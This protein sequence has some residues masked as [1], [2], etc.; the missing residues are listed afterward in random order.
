MSEATTEGDVPRVSTGSDV[1]DTMLGGGLPAQRSVLLTGGPGTG[2]STLAMQFLQQGL[3]EGDECLFLSTE[4]TTE[5]LRMGFQTFDFDLDHEN[6][7]LSTIHAAPRESRTGE[8]EMVIRTLEGE[9]GIDDKQVPFTGENLVKYLDRMGEFDRIV[10]DSV[11]GLEPAA[12]DTETFRRIVLDLIRAINDRLDGT[13]ILTAE[14]SGARA[15]E[16]GAEHVAGTDVIQYSAHGVIRVWREALDGDYQRF[17]DIMK[18][19]GVDHDTRK[20]K[21]GFTDEGMTVYP[22]HRS[23]SD[24]FVQYERFPTGL[25][26][27][28]DLLGG[29]LLQG[30][31]TL[32]EHDG[33]ASL[34]ALFSAMLGSAL[35]DEMAL[36]LVPR[37]DMKPRRLE[38]LLYA[39]DR[40][41]GDLLDDD[42]LFVLD[43]VGAWGMEHRNVFD[44]MNADSGL[45]YLFQQIDDRAA[46]DGRFTMINTE[47]KIHAIGDS[48]ARRIRDWQQ[49]HYVGDD[50]I[51]LEVHNPVQMDDQLSEFHSDA[52]GQVMETYMDESGLQY[53]S[54]TKSPTGLLGSTRVLEFID[55]E[56]Y[57][58]VR[59][60]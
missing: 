5:E 48:E 56:P 2:K 10:F 26:G 59:Q 42:M 53:L 40:E 60:A 45:A 46:G 33:A 43:M 44:V 20:F 12:D 8:E 11:S 34:E 38:T 16:G 52:A 1:L 3:D 18:M 55:E 4:Q 25:E 19:R 17:I 27:L 23:Q 41:V 9:A 29:G 54:L 13:S 36:V 50:D 28:D 47:A 51:L 35:D 49:A 15:G 58:R 14:H 57:V 39:D 30:T 24:H 22:A 37:I 6:L 31:G 7:E 21:L 32:L